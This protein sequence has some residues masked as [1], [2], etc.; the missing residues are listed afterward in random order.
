M[1]SRNLVMRIDD[2]LC[3]L[4]SSSNEDETAPQSV[5]ESLRDISTRTGKIASA[6]TYQR[7]IGGTDAAGVHV[8]SLTEAVMGVTSGLIAIARALDAIGEAI[9][10]TKG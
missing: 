3:D 5:A 7:A 9:R 4:F 2:I 8:R 10:E 6:I 1:K